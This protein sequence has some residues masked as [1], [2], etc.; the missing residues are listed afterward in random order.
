MGT[1][2]LYNKSKYDQWTFI[3]IELG[4]ITIFLMFRERIMR[5]DKDWDIGLQERVH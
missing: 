3:R 5:T 2:Y 1:L 4:L